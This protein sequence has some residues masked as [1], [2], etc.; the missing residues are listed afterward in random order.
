MFPVLRL[1]LML[2]LRIQGLGNGCWLDFAMQDLYSCCNTEIYK[3]CK[4]ITPSE[5]LGA[6]MLLHLQYALNHIGV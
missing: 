2:P 5:M 3:W 1:M 6:F 4:R